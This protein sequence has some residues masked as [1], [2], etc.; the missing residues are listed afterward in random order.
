M[1]VYSAIIIMITEHFFCIYKLY[2]NTCIQIL[3]HGIVDSES[4]SIVSQLTELTQ[5]QLQHP[6]PTPP[7]SSQSSSSSS[8]VSPGAK[9]GGGGGSDEITIGE[10]LGLA[11]AMFALAG[12]QCVQSDEE[13][14]AWRVICACRDS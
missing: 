14:T 2:I 13:M 11:V 4:P 5:K 9:G 7:P 6:S 8:S 1:I 12:E 10:L 3:I